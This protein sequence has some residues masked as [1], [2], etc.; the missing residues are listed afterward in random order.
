ML[1]TKQNT[2]AAEALITISDIVKNI[3]LRPGIADI[4]VGWA[5]GTGRKRR[6]YEVVVSPHNLDRDEWMVSTCKH[7]DISLCGGIPRAI[8]NAVGELVHWVLLE[9]YEWKA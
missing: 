1:T 2:E 5:T 3:A 4:A 8:E 6:A 7:G 9:E